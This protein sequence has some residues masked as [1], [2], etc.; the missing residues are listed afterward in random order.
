MDADPNLFAGSGNNFGSVSGSYSGYVKLYK[1]GQN[2]KEVEL[3]HIC[4]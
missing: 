3:L 1:K 4:R 2:F